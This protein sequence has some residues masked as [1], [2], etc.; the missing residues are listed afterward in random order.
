MVNRTSLNIMDHK[1]PLLVQS[2]PP[3][4]PRGGEHIE[5]HETPSANTTCKIAPLQYKQGRFRPVYK[6]PI[7][8]IHRPSPPLAHTKEKREAANPPYANTPGPVYHDTL[9]LPACRSAGA[10]LSHGYAYD[11]LLEAIEGVLGKHLPSGENSGRSKGRRR[12]R[13]AF[14]CD[15]HLR[16]AGRGRGGGDG[17]IVKDERI[18]RSA[19]LR[20]GQ[21]LRG[22]LAR[23]EAPVAGLEVFW[24]AKEPQ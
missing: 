13:A 19:W 5:H 23:A 14:L 15:I 1:S 11:D 21:G 17:C 12:K 20:E 10:G 7:T 24:W 16:V 22:L 18:I 8:L 6:I 3:Y 2:P 9:S 4:S